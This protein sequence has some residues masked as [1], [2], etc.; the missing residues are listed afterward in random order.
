MNCLRSRASAYINISLQT[1]VKRSLKPRAPASS[2]RAKAEAWRVFP[3]RMF[4]PGLIRESGDT[5]KALATVAAVSPA[6]PRP[7]SGHTAGPLAIPVALRKRFP[8]GSLESQHLGQL[9][10][11]ARGAL[12]RLWMCSSAYPG[13]PQ[14]GAVPQAPFPLF[15]FICTCYRLLRTWGDRPSCHVPAVGSHRTPSCLLSLPCEPT[16]TLHNP[17]SGQRQSHGLSV[18]TD[19]KGEMEV[20]RERP[21]PTP[22]SDNEQEKCCHTHPVL[23]GA[24]WG[25]WGGGQ[26][27]F[28]GEEA[29]S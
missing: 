4:T 3:H 21:F 2:V 19:T 10:A 7:P 24:L 13:L 17:F 18:G 1:C 12:V 6:V 29:E 11:L 9:G 8:P 26:T 23:P 14:R 15:L 20:A 25:D 16:A 27:H 28:T 5:L 22:V